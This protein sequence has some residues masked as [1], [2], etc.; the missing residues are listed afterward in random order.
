TL[1]ALLAA[2]ALLGTVALVALQTLQ[3]L[4]TAVA[5][6]ALLTLE[7]LE[8]LLAAIALVALL[9]L[10]SLE[11]LLA[12][13]ALVALE[14]LRTGVA[15][16]ALIALRTHW[17][18]GRGGVGQQVAEDVDGDFRAGIGGF[19]A[20]GAARSEHDAGFEHQHFALLELE[21][22]GGVGAGRVDGGDAHRSVAVAGGHFEAADDADGVV[23]DL[24]G[25]GI[26]EDDGPKHAAARIAARLL[27][28]V[29][30]AA[31]GMVEAVRDQRRGEPARCAFL[32]HRGKELL[33]PE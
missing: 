16:F 22:G 18:G 12:V 23:G 8:T 27:R 2:Q 13:V 20:E 10:Q 11:A 24:L 26:L 29:R 1:V 15:L 14:A 4:L 5:S 31:A 30:R 9:A 25:A 6:V 19:D 33:L 28:R 17:A 3:A 21:H 32:E 7:T